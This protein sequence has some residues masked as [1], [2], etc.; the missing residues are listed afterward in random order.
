[1]HLTLRLPEIVREK[2]PDVLRK[3][4]AELGGFGLR[5]MLRVGVKADLGPGIHDHAIMPS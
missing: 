4:D 5:A 1:M 3:R 2:T